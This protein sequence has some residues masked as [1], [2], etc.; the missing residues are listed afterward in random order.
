[1][2]FEFRRQLNQLGLAQRCQTRLCE[3]TIDR[4]KAADDCRGRRP[5]AAG[6]WDCVAAPHFQAGH[7][8]TGGLQPVLDGANHQMAR[9]EHQLPGALSL[10][11]DDQPGIG[12]LDD[13]F[14]VEAQC[15]PETVEARAQVGTGGRDHRTG[16]QP[17]S[18]H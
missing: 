10:D 12:C 7:A 1:M 3:K 6:V 17:G 9:V 8:D 2:P 18:K 13:D 4:G 15:Q 14:V 16:Q 5:K 11:L